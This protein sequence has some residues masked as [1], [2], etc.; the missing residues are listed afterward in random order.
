MI[1]Y[2]GIGSRG[3][4][5]D[6]RL[7]V[8]DFAREMAKLVLP[9]G[10]L[11]DAPH[12]KDVVVYSGNADGTDIA[13][14]TGSKG[15]CVIFM[16]WM[17]FN[18]NKY[19]TDTVGCALDVIV[20]SGTVAGNASVEQFHPAPRKLAIGPYKLMCR[21]YHQV[22]GNEGQPN[23]VKYAKLWPKVAFVVCCADPYTAVETQTFQFIEDVRRRGKVVDPREV[24]GGTGQAVRI[25]L[26]Y[27]IPV[28]NF[29]GGPPGE[30]SAQS[31]DRVWDAAMDVI[32]GL[33]PR[34]SE[35]T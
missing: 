15:K 1:S 9:N 13:F 4:T 34:P 11:P 23:G 8:E 25:A 12:A 26:H 7:N 3:I 28:I 16:P 35:G 2:A 6:E 24:K 29:R 33:V 22:M 19:H 5:T 32:K 30:T 17:G 14:Q 27:G 21:N 10:A 20:A 18:S 31:L